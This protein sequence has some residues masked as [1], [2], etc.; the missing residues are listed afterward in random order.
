MNKFLYL[1]FVQDQRDRSNGLL[2]NLRERD[3]QRLRHVKKLVEQKLVL[4]SADYYY[5]A[6]IFQHGERLE[7]IWQAYQLAMKGA[8][9]GF[10]LAYKMAA[11]AYDRWL[12]LQ[13]KPQK[14]GTQYT[15]E[16]DHWELWMVDPAT[17][18][19]ERTKWHVPPLAQAL[20]YAEEIAPR[21][22]GDSH[23]INDNQ[24]K[25]SSSHSCMDDFSI[26]DFL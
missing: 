22:F 5:A 17:T 10:H 7:H 24:Q 11:R 20:K 14:Y 25:A 15:W 26:E 19:E 4:T 23:I 18:D 9:L 1:L 12:M 8:D 2:L 3:R 6:T 13:D 21:N 16:N